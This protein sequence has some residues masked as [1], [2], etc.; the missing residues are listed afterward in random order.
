MVVIGR[1]GHVEVQGIIEDLERFEVVSTEDEVGSLSRPIGSGSSARP[2]PRRGPSS[3]SVRRSPRHNPDA[4]IRFVDT[5]CLPTK[6]HQRS[7]ERLIEQV[8]AMVVVGGQELQQHPRTRQAL[9]R[10]GIPSIHVQG[11]NDLDPDW[12]ARFET[13]GLTAGT[14]TLDSTIDEVHQ[15]MLQMTVKVEA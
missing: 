8:E 5:V 1:R 4:E 11:P 13:V 6:E 9:P 3:A 10:T 14:S 12:L 2:R 15:A 7:L